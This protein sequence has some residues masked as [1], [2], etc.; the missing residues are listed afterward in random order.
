MS[1]LKKLACYTVLFLSCHAI[2][3]Q[4]EYSVKSI[5]FNANTSAGFQAGKPITVTYQYENVGNA[6][7]TNIQVFAYYK[8]ADFGLRQE[9]VFDA[10]SI[11]SFPAGAVATVSY[12]LTSSTAVSHTF[13]GAINTGINLGNINIDVPPKPEQN[14]NNNVREEPVAIFC[15]GSV[16]NISNLQISDERPLV[17][18]EIV[19][20]ASGIRNGAKVV[21]EAG[22]K[23]TL[24][25]GFKA[26]EGANLKARTGDCRND[27]GKLAPFETKSTDPIP[28]T[29]A[30]GVLRIS[31]TEYQGIELLDIKIYPNPA[32]DFLRISGT[33]ETAS[34]KKLA[35][36]NNVKMVKQQQY[37]SQPISEEIIFSLEGIASGVYILEI[38]LANGNIV[39]K[40]VIK[41]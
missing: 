10:Q 22:T 31:K 40:K 28:V 23:I 30:D 17:A 13:G 12:T 5:V 20:T 3:A 35:L 37:S 15:E 2:W 39:T 34:L 33:N 14:I 16:V 8:I 4:P 24:R 9:V 36:Y 6:T 19:I 41:K 29:T 38:T 32:K 1:F 18:E 27:T 7:G 11:A 26:E 21:A 25:N